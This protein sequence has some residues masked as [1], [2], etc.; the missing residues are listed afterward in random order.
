MTE[1]S[2][3]SPW[4]APRWLKLLL[5]ASLA[6]NLGVLGLVGGM[7][8]RLSGP[9]GPPR[10]AAS[11]DFALVAALERDDRRAIFRQLR[12]EHGPRRAPPEGNKAAILA[13]LRAE[14]F[15]RQAMA[16][17][18]SARINHG[19]ERQARAQEIWLVHV[20]GMDA[21]ARRAYADR[22]ENWHPRKHKKRHKRDHQ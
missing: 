20:T 8:W 7:M 15:D 14:S 6:L 21:A 16:A 9:N 12:A 1:Q 19:A 4:R 5:G 18:L 17:L 2:N 13:L 3:T 10:V 22:L 11:G